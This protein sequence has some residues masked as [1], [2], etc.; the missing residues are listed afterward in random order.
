MLPIDIGENLKHL[1]KMSSEGYW[2]RNKRFVLDLTGRV[3]FETVR[4]FLK[5]LIEKLS[6]CLTRS[7]D[8]VKEDVIQKG[9]EAFRYVSGKTCVVVT[10]CISLC[11]HILTSPWV[12]V[13]L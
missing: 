4:S 5:F 12:L 3:T 9:V 13:P 6:E 11:L 10:I 7:V 2:L 1:D 8:V